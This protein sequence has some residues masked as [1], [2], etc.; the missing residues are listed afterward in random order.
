MPAVY[1]LR[2]TVFLK[3]WETN[4]GLEQPSAVS[5]AEEFIWP[6]FNLVEATEG[7]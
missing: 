7:G 2:S 3:Q 6:D 1:L 4:E 5:A